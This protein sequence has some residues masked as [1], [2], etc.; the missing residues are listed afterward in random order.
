VDAKGRIV[1]PARFRK[2]FDTQAFMSQYTDGCVAL[3]TP[4][5]FD[6]Q[7]AAMEARQTHSSE[8]RNMARIWAGTS[9]EVEIDRQGRLAVPA[10]LR[11]FA[12]LESTVLVMGAL[13]RVE[14]WNP[15]AWETRVRPAEDAMIH[16]PDRT[17]A[18]V[19]GS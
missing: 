2:D 11:S 9:A 15:E 7:L 12:Q 5:E 4:E 14:L 8:D 17:V 13:E 1:L 19:A 16:P 6:V 18:S 3:W 10:Y